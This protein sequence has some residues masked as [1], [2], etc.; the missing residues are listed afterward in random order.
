VE[1]PDNGVRN[2]ASMVLF[3]SNATA[4]AKPPT[5]KP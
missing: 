3:I 2:G 5:Q 4:D 1:I